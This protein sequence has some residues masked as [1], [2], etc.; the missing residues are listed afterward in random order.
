MSTPVWQPGTVYAPGAIVAPRTTD[1]VVTEQPNNN[2]FEDGGGSLTDWTVTGEHCTDGDAAAA[3]S[4]STAEAFDG[5]VSATCSPLAGDGTGPNTSGGKPVALIIFTNSFQAAVTPGQ[6]INFK[7][8]AWHLFVPDTSQTYP[9]SAGARIAW[10]D[11]VAMG[12][13]LF[14][15]AAINED[16]LREIDHLVHTEAMDRTMAKFKEVRLLCA[17]ITAC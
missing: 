17:H 16:R 9:W 15:V 10:Y 8:R 5:S 11:R 2:S 6:I 1:I 4:A 7:M 14:N 12:E 3:A 13:P